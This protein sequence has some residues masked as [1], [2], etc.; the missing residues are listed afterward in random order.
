MKHVLYEYGF[1]TVENCLPA[2][3]IVFVYRFRNYKR[4]LISGS[5]AFYVN[6]YNAVL[7]LVSSEEA[8]KNKDSRVDSDVI[9]DSNLI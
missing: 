7:F 6:Y 4:P 2:K 5:H 1:I 3:E 8:A 9:S